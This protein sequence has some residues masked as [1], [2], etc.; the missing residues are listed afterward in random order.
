VML[1]VSYDPSVAE[2]K[3]SGR[4]RKEEREEE[5]AHLG[6]EGSRCLVLVLVAGMR[7]HRT[8]C[9]DAPIPHLP[10]TAFVRLGAAPSPVEDRFHRKRLEKPSAVRDLRLEA[11]RWSLIQRCTFGEGSLERGRNGK[12]WLIPCRL[13]VGERLGELVFDGR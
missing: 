13:V 7:D 4:H 3:L 8:R 2:R 6:H 11:V 1:T 12:C 5:K 9:R 10:D